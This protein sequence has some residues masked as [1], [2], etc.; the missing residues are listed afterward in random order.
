MEEEPVTVVE[1]PD[2]VETQ[3]EPVEEPV[4]DS[5]VE[6]KA[7]ENELTPLAVEFAAVVKV[8]TEEAPIDPVEEDQAGEA[9]EDGE[10]RHLEQ[11]AGAKGDPHCKLSETQLHRSK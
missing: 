4:V 3:P 1:E 9:T 10:V 6:Q 7:T 5:V 11:A 2:V 8:T